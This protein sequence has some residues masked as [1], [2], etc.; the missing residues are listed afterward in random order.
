MPETIE[1]GQALIYNGPYGGAVP[2][3]GAPSGRV[4]EAGKQSPNITA[5]PADVEWLLARGFQREDV[6]EMDSQITGPTTEDLQARI[7]ELEQQLALAQSADPSKEYPNNA[8]LRVNPE[9]ANTVRPDSD[10]TALDEQQDNN[11]AVDPNSTPEKPEQADP[12]ALRNIVAPR[13]DDQPKRGRP[14]KSDD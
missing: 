4:Y 10:T 14:R 5:D 9:D 11:L 1:N 3:S 2:F 13:D 8:V 6:P 7:A 12:D